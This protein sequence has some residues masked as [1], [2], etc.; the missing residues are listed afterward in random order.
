M[1]TEGGRATRP[2]WGLEKVPQKGKD[3][4]YDFTGKDS[5]GRK[6]WKQWQEEWSSKK[7]Q[8]HARLCWPALSPLQLLPVSSPFFL[9]N[10]ALLWKSWFQPLHQGW[11]Q[12]LDRESITFLSQMWLANKWAP[13][14]KQANQ[15]Q[16]ELI[17]YLTWAPMW[18]GPSFSWICSC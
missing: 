12:D 11:A 13:D 17:L 5:A 4:G 3:L 2:L 15:I 6:S 8:E 7:R 14:P 10:A 16:P 1:E 9:C 18:E